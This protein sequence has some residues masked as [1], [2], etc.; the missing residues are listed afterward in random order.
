MD[1]TR[2]DWDGILQGSLTDSVILSTART[3]RSLPTVSTPSSVTTS[4]ASRRS[5]PTVVSDTTGA[6][7]SVVSTPRP[8]AV[9]A[10]LSVSPRRRVVK[11]N[12][13][14]STLA[15]REFG[16]EQTRLGGLQQHGSLTRFYCIAATAPCGWF[17]VLYGSRRLE[18]LIRQHHH[19]HWHQAGVRNETGIPLKTERNC[20]IENGIMKTQTDFARP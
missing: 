8:L 7:A 18:I 1:E 17:G 6:C 13:Q 5:A 4:S 20:G 11:K 9:A 15:S 3:T 14:R 12:G 2:T 19:R 16:G 10:G